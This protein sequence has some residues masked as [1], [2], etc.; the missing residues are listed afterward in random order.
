MLP[1][2]V[3]DGAH[4]YPD[5]RRS[6]AEH[7]MF[8]VAGG[9]AVQGLLVA[10]AADGIGSCWVSATIFCADVVREVL[11]LPVCWEPLGA[12]AVGYPVEG[13]MSPRPPREDP[14]GLLSR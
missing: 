7:T 13:T 10:L 6:E 9:A 4:D 5:A 1:F 2:L 8:V 3:A 11:D 12:V 14:E